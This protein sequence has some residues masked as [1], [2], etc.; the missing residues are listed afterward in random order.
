MTACINK[1]GIGVGTSVTNFGNSK[2]PVGTVIDADFDVRVSY[3]NLPAAYKTAPVI[4]FYTDSIIRSGGIKD[5]P[6][7]YDQGIGPVTAYNGT[8]TGSTRTES[9]VPNLL[10][11]PKGERCYSFTAKD[12]SVNNG[13]P[14]KAGLRYP[15]VLTTPVVSFNLGL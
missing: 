8:G 11:I 9:I 15:Y 14:C 13:L 1:N 3:P 12:F 6:A 4:F 2:R 10:V 7:E 5:P